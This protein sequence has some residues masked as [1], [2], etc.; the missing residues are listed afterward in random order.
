MLGFLVMLLV[1]AI[2]GFVGE[3]LAPGGVPGGWIGAI[4]AGLV[5]SALGGYLFGSW[6]PSLAGFALIPAILGAAIVV[7]LFNLVARGLS[8]AR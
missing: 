2:I 8:R 4:V 7:L 1:A 5:G 6:G 3:A